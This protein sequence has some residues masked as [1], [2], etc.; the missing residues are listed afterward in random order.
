[1]AIQKI[2]LDKLYFQTTQGNGEGIKK[3]NC[4]LQKEQLKA[5]RSITF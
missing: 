1:M 5:A 3:S 4:R 2:F